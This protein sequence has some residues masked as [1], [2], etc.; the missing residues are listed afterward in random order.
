MAAVAVTE[1]TPVYAGAGAGAPKSKATEMPKAVGSGVGTYKRKFA[2]ADLLSTDTPMHDVVCFTSKQNTLYMIEKKYIMSSNTIKTVINCG[3]E[4]GEDAE[5]EDEMDTRPVSGV[6]IAEL[7]SNA[8]PLSMVSDEI[9]PILF[10]YFKMNDIEPYKMIPETERKIN[11]YRHKVFNGDVIKQS[12]YADFIEEVF[13]MGGGVIY[14]VITLADYLN[15]E[16]LM[17]LASVYVAFLIK[18]SGGPEQVL[19]RFGVPV[20]LGT[21]GEE[22]FKELEDM[23]DVY[24]EYI[25]I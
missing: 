9:V 4:D 3:D 24:E 11:P 17:E 23:K 12:Q 16:G 22:Q 1:T 7:E 5:D 13:N 8:F 20:D 6:S 25:K 19:E 14:D 10:D 2:T 18:T 15:I 21:I